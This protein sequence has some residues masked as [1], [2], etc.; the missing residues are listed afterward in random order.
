MKKLS[1]ED[2]RKE[3][4]SIPDWYLDKDALRRDWQF[5]DFKEALKFINLVGTIAE[6]HN[7]HPE[8]INVYNKVTLRFNTHDAGG[9]TEKDFIVVRAIDHQK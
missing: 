2:V 3:L 1:Q 5:T 7:H 8:L 4:N 9:I 6:K